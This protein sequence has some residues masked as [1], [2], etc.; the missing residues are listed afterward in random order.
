MDDAEFDALRNKLIKAGSDAVKHQ[1]SSYKVLDNGQKEAKADLYPEEGKNS[2]L[3]APAFFQ[4]GLVFMELAYWIKGWDPLL[5]LI[6]TSPLIAASTWLLTNKIYF[7]DPL[8]TRYVNACFVSFCCDRVC[9]CRIN[10]KQCRSPRAHTRIQEA[11]ATIQLLSN[12]RHVC[13]CVWCVCTHTH[14]HTQCRDGTTCPPVR[15]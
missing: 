10:S 7:Q 1:A 3:Y 6:V 13:V 8:I 12:T 9:E 14:T 2:I 4:T 5:S 11:N 15:E